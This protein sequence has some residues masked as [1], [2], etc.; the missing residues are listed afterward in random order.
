V[1]L[2]KLHA[3]IGFDV[4]ER[5]QKLFGFYKKTG[6]VSEAHWVAKRLDRTSTD[7]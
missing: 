7:F 3:S 6:L 5:Y 4:V 2:R 1:C